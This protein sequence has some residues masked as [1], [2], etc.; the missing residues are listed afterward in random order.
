MTRFLCPKC[1]TRS[2]VTVSESVLGVAVR[3]ERCPRCGGE[4]LDA[5]ERERLTEQYH[6]LQSL[7]EACDR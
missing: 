7:L 4:F 6:K 3:I 5:G 1:R 2:M